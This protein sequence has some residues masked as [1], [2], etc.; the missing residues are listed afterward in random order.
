MSNDKDF[1]NDPIFKDLR[2]F[3]QKQTGPETMP[4]ELFEAFR[5]ANTTQVR[6]KWI[7][8][9]IIGVL[10]TAVALP[11]LAAAH[12]LP[13]PVS[14][15][16]NRVVHVVAAPIRV[17]AS[18]VSNEPAPTENVVA[19]PTPT[20][21]DAPATPTQT[22]APAPIQSVGPAPKVGSKEDDD[23][24]ESKPISKST[25]KPIASP[26]GKHED[27]AEGDDDGAAPKLP[28][29]GT[30]SAPAVGGS[31]GEK[32]ES[33]TETKSESKSGSSEKEDD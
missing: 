3:A 8:R 31:T 19:T 28:S 18:V 5:S 24:E 15:V 25:T 10:F 14:N 20:T 1:T 16:V 11:S 12:V 9:S 22:L 33:K 6:S 26:T 32:V 4:A 29:G 30:V 7:S 27:E 23:E 13:K 2:K 17:V 21:S